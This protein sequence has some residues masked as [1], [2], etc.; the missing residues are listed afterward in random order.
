[1]Q[2]ELLDDWDQRCVTSVL[3]WD[4]GQG[5]LTL[6]QTAETAGDSK[7][8]LDGRVHYQVWITSVDSE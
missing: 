7:G 5:S 4:R 3:R 2:C 1:M 6:E 8:R